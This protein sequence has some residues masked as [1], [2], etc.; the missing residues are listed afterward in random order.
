MPLPR[1]T[2][3]VAVTVISLTNHAVLPL[4]L[5]RPTCM[6]SIRTEKLHL[7]APSVSKQGCFA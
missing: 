5:P 4:W 7:S 2:D 3:A 1:P 6:S